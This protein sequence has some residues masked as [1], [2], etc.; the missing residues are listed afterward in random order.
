MLSVLAEFWDWAWGHGREPMPPRPVRE[1]QPPVRVMVPV[2]D[3]RSGSVVSGA[4]L[5]RPAD[6]ETAASTPEGASAN[7]EEAQDSRDPRDSLV[8]QEPPALPQAGQ[9]LWPQVAADGLWYLDVPVLSMVGDDVIPLAAPSSGAGLGGTPAPVAA[10]PTSAMSTMASVWSNALM[11]VDKVAGSS[12][13]LGAAT[14]SAVASA[15]HST[16]AATVPAVADTTPPSVPVT[17]SASSLHAG[18]STTVQFTLSESSTS[19]TQASVVAVGGTLSH[20]SGSGTVYSATFTPTANSMVAGRVSVAS[21]QFRD[22]AGNLNSDGADTNNRVDFSIDTVA[23]A[24]PRALLDGSWAINP[25]VT[26]QVN[27][28]NGNVQDIVVELFP[29][30]VGV[31]VSNW[32]AY[33]N[34]HFYDSLIFHRVIPGF[35]AQTG[36]YSSSL[37]QKT[38]TYDA[39]PLESGIPGLSNEADTIAMARTTAADSATSQFYF[40][41]VNN[42]SL[43]YSSASSP[44]YAVF[45]QVVSGM[46]TVQ[47]IGA[48][49]TSTQNGMAD[50][51]TSPISLVSAAVSQAGTAYSS[52]G[53]IDLSGL[54]TGGQWSY[55]LDGG[56]VWQP[57]VLSQIDLGGTPGHKVVSIRQ[58][59]SAGNVSATS[60]LEFTQYT[61][62]DLHSVL[63]LATASD[64][65]GGAAGTD[66]DN[67]TQSST[68]SLSALLASWANAQVWLMDQGQYVASATAD[69]TGALNWQVTGVTTGNH[70]Y[71]LYDPLHHVRIIADGGVAVSE[72]HVRVL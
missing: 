45:G 47:A 4:R 50:V 68:L 42:T 35:V 16:A 3:D 18:Q 43:D 31:T 11:A 60:T 20:F 58:T 33:V 30:E 38:A 17:A 53:L 55:S 21:Q 22:A 52:T 7:A 32:L 54:E 66:Q 2:P 36:G 44:G 56:V 1:M 27:L 24:P 6:P 26:L 64:S 49:A 23:P 69:S 29:N 71:T 5:T 67:V 61:P 13:L 72:L 59:D 37:I 10:A 63:D 48:S 65:T 9:A 25:Q 40:N 62:D 34:T 41:L 19:F 57:V 39:I 15:G 70:A 12:M 28:G 14:A 46:S 51:P 8:S